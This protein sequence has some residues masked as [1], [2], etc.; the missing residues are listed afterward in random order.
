M[1]E[2]YGATILNGKPS[3]MKNGCVDYFNK[4]GYTPEI[5]LSNI[6][7]DKNLDYIHYSG[8]EDIKDMTFYSGKYEGGVIVGNNPHLIIFANG[9][10][11]T[12]NNKF[13]HM[14]I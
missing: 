3:D 14:K 6:G 1:C 11:C 9:E 13:R 2:K 8:Y 5:I 7:F 10:P 4:N 12:E